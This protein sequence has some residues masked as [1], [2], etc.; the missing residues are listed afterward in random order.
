MSGRITRFC[1]LEHRGRILGRRSTPFARAAIAALAALL[2]QEKAAAA[3]SFPAAEGSAHP[4]LLARLPDGRRINFRCAGQGAP[5]VLFESG[6]GADSLLWPRVQL[7]EAK[8][9]RACAY[10]RAG[11]GFSDP[12]PMPRDGAA[13]AKDLDEALRAADIRGPFIVVAHS[14]GGLY[15]RLFADRRPRDVVGLVLVEPSV[16]H[17]ERR[18]DD[19]F[20]PGAG[21]L[22]GTRDRTVRCL[23]AAQ[24]G[25]LPSADPAL[26]PC[27][28]LVQASQPPAVQAARLA[29]ARRPSRWQAQ[30]SELDNLWTT[31][32][33]EIDR[34]R[35]SYGDLPLIVL[36]ADGG[37]PSAPAPLSAGTS[38]TMS[39]HQ[40]IARRSTRGE[41]RRVTESSHMMMF[42]R[43]DAI[44]KA[45][46]DVAAEAK[47]A[48]SP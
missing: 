26:A 16:E 4:G 38:F 33:D 24:S 7:Q 15:A 12:G 8:L 43:P 14:S 44:L 25:V 11:A 32:S 3:P 47:A 39:L 41:D 27:T 40:E 22:A 29:E 28:G 34:G 2:V 48:K 13:I 18:V 1:T 30:I 35:A 23:A 5:T 31:T 19:A 17:Q 21:S 9:R 10:D 42:D 20:G 6:F 46:A 36:T 45:I 37:R